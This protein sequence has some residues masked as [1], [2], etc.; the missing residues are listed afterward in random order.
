METI[1]R[2]ACGEVTIATNSKPLFKMVCH[3]NDCKKFTGS[4]YA[5]LALFLKEKVTIS[6]QL[7]SHVVIGGS[8]NPVTRQACAKCGTSM[9]STADV[10][11][12]FVGILAGTLNIDFKP[13]THVFTSRKSPNVVIPEGVKQRQEGM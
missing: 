9:L 13:T 1:A 8:G 2:C 4:D 11:P 5:P 3:C 12:Q 10:M 7:T 6:G